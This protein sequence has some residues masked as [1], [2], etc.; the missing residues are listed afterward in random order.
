MS[1]TEAHQEVAG[2]TQRIGELELQLFQLARNYLD[3]LNSQLSRR[4]RRWGALA[5]SWSAFPAREVEFARLSRE[6]ELLTEIYG[7]L[8]T[9]LKEAEIRE[10]V[11]PGDVRVV[12][13][14]L[15]PLRP[16]YPTPGRTL[17]LAL[18]LGLFLGVGV[19]CCAK[20]WTPASAAVR[21]PRTPP[22]ERRS[23]G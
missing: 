9:R 4:R 5:R 2:I 8:Q 6:Q 19:A 12:D 23:W 18:A 10:A 17:T 16:V 15:V 1:R 13:S 21:T 20:R 11:E 7:L 22:A 3:G 14:A